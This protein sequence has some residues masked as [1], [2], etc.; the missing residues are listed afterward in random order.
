S[1]VPVDDYHMSDYSALY[2]QAMGVMGIFAPGYIHVS[3]PDTG[4]R[5]APKVVELGCPVV[6]ADYSEVTAKL[7]MHLSRAD[8]GDAAETAP[9]AENVAVRTTYT[10][11]TEEVTI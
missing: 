5:R 9:V 6:G 4:A 8:F 1:F 11:M 3:D 2:R 10:T 7:S